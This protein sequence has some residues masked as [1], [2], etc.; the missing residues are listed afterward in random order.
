MQ[1]PHHLDLARTLAAERQRTSG[2]PDPTA[3][4][5]S[6]SSSYG[7]REWIGHKLINL[8]ERLTPKPTD[9]KPRVSTG[10]PCP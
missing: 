5:T 1:G 4:T 10:H 6:D 8:G 3:S 7:L 9:L 2:H